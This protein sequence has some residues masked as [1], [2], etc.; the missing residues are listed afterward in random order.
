MSQAR[1]PTQ[2]SL[3]YS[4]VELLIVL[5]LLG[6]L[7]A[8]VA[9]LAQTAAQRERE[10]ELKRSL[11]E[12]R[13]AID[14]YRRAVEGGLIAPS[15]DGSPY[16][17]SLRALTQGVPDLHVVGRRHTFLRRLPRDPFAAE[18]GS[19]DASWGLRSY[20][21]PPHRPQAGADVYDVYSRSELVGL[22]GVPLKDW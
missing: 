15:T 7:A 1:M 3:G 8:A 22:N 9:P 4:L 18:Q 14:A 5:A 6:V 11:W 2:R 16:P 21:S 20:Q 17:P 12:M 19:A 13:D 10:R